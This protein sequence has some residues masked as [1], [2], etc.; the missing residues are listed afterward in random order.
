MSIPGSD[1]SQP[2]SPTKASKRSACIIA[3]TESAM[4]SRLTREACMPS[5]PIE[6]PSET[7]M[8]TNSKGKPPAARTPSLARLCEPGERQVARRHLVPGRRHPDLRLVEVAFCHSDGPEH[9]PRRRAAEALGD[10]LAVDLHR[11]GLL[12]HQL[13]LSP[14]RA[15]PATRPAPRPLEAA[16]GHDLAAPRRAPQARG[17]PSQPCRLAAKAAATSLPLARPFEM[18]MTWP[19]RNCTTLSSPSR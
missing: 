2:A 12:G 4:I 1:L 3:S 19:R 18:R 8:E 10:V 6:M 7:A 16:R 15:R 13:T 11:A 9:R 5:W 14:S 17:P